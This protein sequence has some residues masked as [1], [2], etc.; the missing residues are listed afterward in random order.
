MFHSE[1]FVVASKLFFHFFSSLILLVIS[2]TIII[3]FACIKCFCFPLFSLDS[4]YIKVLNRS[5]ANVFLKLCCD[6]LRA[7]V[8]D[9]YKYNS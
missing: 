6:C 2:S 8:R 5:K 1:S 4:A 9:K 3:S 7:C